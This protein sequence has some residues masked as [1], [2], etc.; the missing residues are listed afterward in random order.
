MKNSDGE[1]V[2]GLFEIDSMKVNK[3]TGGNV[4]IGCG[5]EFGGGGD[6]VD[7]NAE[8]VNNVIDESFGF[9]LQEIPM[10]KKDF[11]EYLGGYCKKVRQALKDDS[12]VTGPEVK[13]FTQAA[14]VFCKFLLSMYDEIVFYVSPAMD[15]DAAMVSF[16]SSHPLDCCY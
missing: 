4:D 15:P 10:G 2:P 9:N 16:N 12:T 14:P 8:I 7:D 6:D 11:K 3:D 1:E 5:N 13:S